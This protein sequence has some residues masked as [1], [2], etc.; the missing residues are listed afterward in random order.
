MDDHHGAA[1]T[2]SC[3]QTVLHCS[4]DEYP[5]LIA[6]LHDD[7]YR[8]CV[9]V[10]AVDSLTNS[11]RVLPPDVVPERF[12]VVVNLLDM[13]R[14][15]RIRVRA[16]VPADPAEVATVTHLFPGAEAPE[17]EAADLFGI[18]FLGHPDPS[19][20]LMPEDWDGH[21]LRKDY[22]IGAIPVQFKAVRNR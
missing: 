14:R 8:F 12:E 20:I 10:C 17:R 19:R 2:Q 4:A 13:A 18:A 6:A 1:T 11:D 3:G 16:Q 5:A 15:R 21:P 22:D 7:G 9:D